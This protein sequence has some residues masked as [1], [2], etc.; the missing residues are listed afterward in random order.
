MNES[1][2]VNAEIDRAHDATSNGVTLDPN[3][4]SNSN[5]NPNPNQILNLGFYVFFFKLK[6]NAFG[7]A[8]KPKIQNGAP[9]YLTSFGVFSDFR[10][11]K[12]VE[13]LWELRSIKL[14]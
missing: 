3:P 8:T 6:K 12:D 10:L 1:R 9:S 11:R 5:I 4:N 7:N 2:V 13:S 14:A